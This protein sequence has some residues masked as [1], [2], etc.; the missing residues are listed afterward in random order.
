MRIPMLAAVTALAMTASLATPS[1]AR[2]TTAEAQVRATGRQWLAHYLA[3]EVEPLMK[4][5]TPDAVVAL[6][7]QPKLSGIAAIRAYFAP[8]LAK[9]P[10]A[11]FRLREESI[12][13]TGN[14][15]L[16]MAQYWLTLRL[17]D[18]R[19]VT[20]AGRSLIVYRRDP[21]QG[22]RI[23]IDID[24]ATPDVAFPVPADAR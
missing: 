10:N 7:G 22:W 9:K 20:D 18:G 21:G 5:Y 12:S 3:G 11:D 23:A 13:V 24:Q 4:L 1:Q 15:A 17:P 8:R 19:T 6:H 16:S 2:E 14:Q